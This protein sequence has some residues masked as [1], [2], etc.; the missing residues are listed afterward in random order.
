MSKPVV[1]FRRASLPLATIEVEN[2]ETLL[3]AAC[4]AGLEVPSSCT[5]GT[6]GTCMMRLVSG[7]V[8]GLDPLPP[9][10]DEDIV[11]DGAILTCIGRAV[12]SCVI[13]VIPPL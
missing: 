3:E 12:S 7:E 9:G 13:D 8:D 6:C 4:K 11:A 10:L 5:S 2:H 1:R